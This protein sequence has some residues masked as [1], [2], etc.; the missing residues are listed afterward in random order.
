[1][2]TV[3]QAS[4]YTVMCIYLFTAKE[5]GDEFGRLLLGSRLLGSRLLG[6]RL[7]GSRLLDSRLLLR[8][9]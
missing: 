6:S 4:K 1:M 9:L 3:Q 7:L 5:G 8:V 2:N